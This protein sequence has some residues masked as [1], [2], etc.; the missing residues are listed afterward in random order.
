[1]FEDVGGGCHSP[2]PVPALYLCVAGVAGG[3]TCLTFRKL[4]P[5]KEKYK[6][7]EKQQK[8]V[9]LKTPNIHEHILPKEILKN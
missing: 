6:N 1:M 4:F 3:I 5:E 8:N 9:F 7:Q 2:G